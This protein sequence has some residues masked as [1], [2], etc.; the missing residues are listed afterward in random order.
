MK[1]VE[2]KIIYSPSDLLTYFNSPFASWMDRYFLENPSKLKPDELSKQAQHIISLGNKHERDILNEI[3]EQGVGVAKINS[4]DISKARENTRA[5]FLSKVP[6]IYQAFLEYENFAGFAD[7]VILNNNKEYQVWDTKL[8]FS[9]KPTYVIQLCFYYEAL[10]NIENVPLSKK[11]GLIYGS[12][13]K[14]EYSVEDFFYFYSH[15]KQ[16]FLKMQSSFTNNIK[17]RPEPLRRADHGRWDSYA[18]D[19]FN[20]TDHLTKIARISSSNIKKLQEAGV[21]T[22]NDVAN[23]SLDK[24]VKIEKN[25][26]KQIIQQ[27]KLQVITEQKRKKD[28][29]AVPEYVVIKDNESKRLGVGSLPKESDEDVF[30]DMEGYPLMQGGLEYLFGASVKNKKTKKLEFYDWWAHSRKEEKVALEGF[31]DWA[32]KRWQKNKK[33]HIYHYAAYEVTAIRKLSTRH[34]TRQDEVDVLLRN[35]VFVDLYKIIKNGIMIGTE[36]YSIKDVE[37]LYRPKRDTNVSSG[38]D[39]IVQ[40]AEWIASGQS[41]DPSKSSIL[42]DIRKY[43]KDDCDSTAE[44]VDWLRKIAKE[45]NIEAGNKEEE[46]DGVV[47]V[48]L[49]EEVKERKVLEERLSKKKDKISLFLA[50]I[51]DFYRREDKAKWWRMFDLRD[52]QENELF[53]DMD[54]IA[55]VKAVLSPYSEKQSLL[56]KYKFNPSQDCKISNSNK[57]PLMFKDNLEVKFTVADINTSSG[58]VILKLSKRKLEETLNGVFPQSGSLIPY[59][60]ISSNVMQASLTKISK[61]YLEGKI[62]KTTLSII[63]RQKIEDDDRK[64]EESGCDILQRIIVKMENGCLVVQGPPGTGKTY[65]A[66]HVISNLLLKNKKVGI[67]S[68]SHKAVDNL[69]KAVSQVL[70]EKNNTLKGVRVGGDKNNKIFKENP[71]LLFL[72]SSSLARESYQGGII[73]GTA[74]LFSR[75]EWEKELDYLFIDEAGQVSLANVTAMSPCAKNIILLGD[76]MQL[77]QPIQGQHPRDAKLSSLQYALKDDLLSTDDKPVFYA[78]VPPYY[79]IFLKESRR[80]HPSVCNFI[81]ESIY[82]GRLLSHKDCKNQKIIY[83]KE[84]QKIIKKDSGIVFVNVEHNKNTRKSKEEVEKIVDIYDELIKGEYISSRKIKRKLTLDD[85]LFIA[86]YNAQVTALKEKL[87]EGARVGTI[88]KFQGQQAP[89]CIISLCMSYGEQRER[90]ISFILDKNRINVAI[91]R[92]QCLAVVVGDKRIANN[93]AQTIDEVKQINLFC[94]LINY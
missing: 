33:M 27:A 67:S 6:V 23:L 42:S 38:S 58:E 62:N 78:V 20:K 49:S 43:N 79:G 28:P 70:T 82:E 51:I 81:S 86:P 19:Y 91:S 59:E 54:C 35:N 68:N 93:C 75:L 10:K 64:K 71:E 11:I 74:W 45:N 50:D 13:E 34:N 30:F 1:K 94:K 76:Q 92:T 21:T 5:S 41:K 60:H 16:E 77:K 44:L 88:D 18:E 55:G 73:A 37:L 17:D 57:T 25:K 15:L 84:N 3:E 63:N 46:E 72:D 90:G 12:K 2:Q 24:E 47:E 39:S 32:Y 26:L 29:L 87:P 85:F 53:D 66:S 83:D 4:K 56:Q 31:V 8:A 65:T 7:F 52:A 40:Y 48:E 9:L 69:I 80:M 22:V 89:V 36:S 14:E 61:D